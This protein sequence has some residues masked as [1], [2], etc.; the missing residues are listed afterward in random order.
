VK[1]K[2]S[3]LMMQPHRLLLTAA[4]E[5]WRTTRHRE[6][7]A[8]SW[9]KRFPTNLADEDVSAFFQKLNFKI[10]QIVQRIASKHIKCKRIPEKNSSD[11]IMAFMRL[12]CAGTA[13]VPLS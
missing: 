3:N 9:H 13:M 12:I 2:K 7:N 1:I 4:H 11:D 6:S 5:G 10:S 8:F